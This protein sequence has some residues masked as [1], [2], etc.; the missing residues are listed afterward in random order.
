MDQT[1]LTELLLGPADPLRFRLFGTA[2][3]AT[4]AVIAV[5]GTAFIVGTGTW[6]TP[7]TARRIGRYLGVFIIT[8]EVL[9][10]AGHHYLNGEPFTH[11]LPLHMC[12]VSV[13][14]TALLLITPNRPVFHLMYFWGICGATVALLTPDIQFGFPH[15]LYVTYFSSHGLI[16][17]GVVYTMQ[18][19]RYRPTL[20]SLV[21]VIA[22]SFAYMAAVFPV[23]LLLQSNYLFLRYKPEAPSPMDFF[24]PWP[25][26][27]LWLIVCGI[28]AFCVA[29]SPFF[30]YD[31]LT[32][33]HGPA[34]QARTEAGQEER[35]RN[36]CV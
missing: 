4:L 24:G 28:L 2:H 33:R 15:I 23:N 17:V 18:S 22:F 31:L 20:R 21:A 6:T 10:R 13:F 30:A 3:L 35:S 27:I 26:Y 29:Y 7:A 9:D 32:C 11:I 1:P 19:R 16:I 14:L 25:W 34:E 8:Q 5:L 36:G 12:G